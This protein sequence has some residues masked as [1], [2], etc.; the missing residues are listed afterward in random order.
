MEN[1]AIKVVLC[2]TD[3]DTTIFIKAICSDG[4]SVDVYADDTDI[5]CLLLHHTSCLDPGKKNFMSSMKCDKFFW[6]AYHL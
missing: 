6:A 2:D 4:E 5:L 3:A 1:E